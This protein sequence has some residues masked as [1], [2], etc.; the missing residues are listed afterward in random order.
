MGSGDLKGLP[1]APAKQMSRTEMPT[2]RH[3]QEAR[4]DQPRPHLLQLPAWAGQASLSCALLFLAS[5]LTV[6]VLGKIRKLGKDLS[7]P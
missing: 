3:P 1:A 2:L 4:Q 6:W 5:A 7:P